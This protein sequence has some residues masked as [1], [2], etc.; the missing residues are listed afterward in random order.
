MLEVNT[1]VLETNAL[2]TC[3][4]ASATHTAICNYKQLP[5]RNYVKMIAIHKYSPPKTG[6]V[7]LMYSPLSKPSHCRHVLYIRV[8]TLVE[9]TII[10]FLLSHSS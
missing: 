9:K 6:S 4:Q 10:E 3:I 7:T 8:C 2:K 1:L 5:N